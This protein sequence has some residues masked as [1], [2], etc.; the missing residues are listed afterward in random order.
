MFAPSVVDVVRSPYAKLAHLDF[1]DKKT[2][3]LIFKLNIPF[4]LC[5][6]LYEVISIA[7]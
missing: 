5:D 4:L 6:L 1:K 2:I 7:L 3:E